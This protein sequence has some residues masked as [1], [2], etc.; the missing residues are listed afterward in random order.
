MP[1][2]LG[3]PGVVAV[4]LERGHP[5]ALV[6]E[7][8]PARYQVLHEVG[9]ATG[10]QGHASGHGHDPAAAAGDLLQHRY[11]VR[12]GDVMPGDHI[13][14]GAPAG[15][16]DRGVHRRHIPDI[17]QRAAAA[18]GAAA[19]R[20]L[21]DDPVGVTQVRV[22]RPDHPS[23][24][25]NHHRSALV[26]VAARDLLRFSLGPR[27]GAAWPRH[28]RIG[29]QYS[30]P[31][32]G[33]EKRH[34]AGDVHDRIQPH[35]DRRF[36]DDLGGAHVSGA[37]TRGRS[38]VG[39]VDGRRVQHRVAARHGFLRRRWHGHVTH[40]GIDVCHPQRVKAAGH[41]VTRPHEQP[42][43]MPPGHKGGDR[44]RADEPGPSRDKH[45]HLP[46]PHPRTRDRN[47]RPYR[48][49]RGRGERR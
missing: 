42:D 27:V 32:L 1:S 37:D 17:D 13:A 47:V 10:G 49:Y 6:V 45:S 4:R 9:H 39:R 38:R 33:R 34:V 3:G 23:R 7:G 8:E 31:R 25:D 24:V 16:H 41:L 20:E 14:A 29:G 15:L 44:M 48:H 11:E 2:S 22:I 19:F 28:R 12:Q 43:L 18:H 26:L 40:D 21:C 35:A 36:Q 30:A 46:T 5:Y